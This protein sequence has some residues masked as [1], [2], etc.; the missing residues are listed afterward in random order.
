MI[1]LNVTQFLEKIALVSNC[2]VKRET[3]WVISNILAG[4][5]KHVEYILNKTEL[6]KIMERHSQDKD[7]DVIN[8]FIF[9]LE[10]RL[11]TG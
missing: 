1:N 6:L 3:C 9:R 8:I 10:E 11:Y 5:K 7:K 4:P 2:Q